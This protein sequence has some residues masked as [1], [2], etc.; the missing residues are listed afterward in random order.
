MPQI[1]IFFLLH[2]QLRGQLLQLLGQL[3]QLRGQLLQL[4]GQ[5]FQLRGQLL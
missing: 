5:L 3:F 4:L 1:L 2:F